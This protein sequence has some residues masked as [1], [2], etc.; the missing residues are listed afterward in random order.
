MKWICFVVLILAGCASRA[1]E[2]PCLTSIHLVDSNG[3]MQNVGSPDRLKRFAAVDFSKPQ[4]YSRVLRVFRTESNGATPSILTSY[5][6]SGTIKQWLDIVSNRACGR[7]M[8]WYENG[9]CKISARVISGTPDFSEAAVASWFFDGPAE[10]FDSSGQKTAH[11]E[12]CRGKLNGIVRRWNSKGLLIEEESFAMGRRCGH[13]KRI[14]DN[15]SVFADEVFEDDRLVEGIYPGAQVMKGTGWCLRPVEGGVLWQEVQNGLLDG[16]VREL[17]GEELVHSYTQHNDQKQGLEIF[18][19][20]EQ[21][22]L[23]IPYVDG[24]IQGEVKTRYPDGT[25][26]SIREMSNNQKEGQLRCWYRNGQIM[27]VEQYKE[28]RLQS[29]EY[30]A[31]GSLTPQARVAQ[32]RGD[33]LVFDGEGKL[34][35][36]V[37]YIDG[38]PQE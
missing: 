2:R 19:E 22:I 16:Q 3:M 27:M 34:Q 30:Y 5:W 21:P 20:K 4:G 26:E 12:Y 33:A 36:R 18:Y 1:P 9:Q 6:P 23:E 11:M 10:A 37:T 25:L 15:G 29:G 24:V 32:G 14:L 13:A 8:E 28:G 38:L 17:R 7:Y 31:L 35:R